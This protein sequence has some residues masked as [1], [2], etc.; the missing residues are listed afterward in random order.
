MELLV[1]DRKDWKMTRVL[2]DFG[3]LNDA[4]GQF[5]LSVGGENE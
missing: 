1:L 2:L 4:Q 5:F 3:S